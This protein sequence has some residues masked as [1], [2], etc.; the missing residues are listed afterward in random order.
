MENEIRLRGAEERDMEDLLEWRNHPEVRKNFFNSAAVSL[1]EHA[2]WFRK[3]L[4]DSKTAIYM[5]LIGEDKIGSIR[6][7]DSGDAIKTSVMLNPAFF[8]TGLGSKVVIAGTRKFLR[9]NKTEKPIIAEIK[10][11]NIASINAFEKAGFK[12]GFRT[13]IFDVTGSKE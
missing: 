3:K 6:F 4:S 2:K 12:E 10:K 8:G 1:E 5:A 11:D 7:E 13:F 9:E